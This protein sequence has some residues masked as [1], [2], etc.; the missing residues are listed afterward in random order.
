MLTTEHAEKIAKK[1]KAKIEKSQKGHDYA[2]IFFGGKLIAYFG[3]RRS[4]KDT[5]HDHIPRMIFLPPHKTKQ[6]AICTM[7]YEEWI[8]R[9]KELEKI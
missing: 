1:L 7:S 8:E 2:R 6:L 4:S 9:M 3:I 5:G